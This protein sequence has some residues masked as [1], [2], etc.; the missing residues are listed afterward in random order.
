MNA[1][2]RFFFVATA[3]LVFAAASLAVEV[4]GAWKG[5]IVIDAR[6]MPKPTDQKQRQAMENGLAMIRRMVIDLNLR[7][8]RTFAVRM[9]GGPQGQPPRRAEGKWSQSGNRITLST[10]TEDGKPAKKGP[11]STQTFTLAPNGR[12]MSMTLPGHGP[13]T[14]KMVFRR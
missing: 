4:T 12:T 8:N 9:S 3:V 14:A 7:P 6:Q 13:V 11:N 1:F 10:T 2:I 5:Q